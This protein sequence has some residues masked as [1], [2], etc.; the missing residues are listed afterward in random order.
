M[1]EDSQCHPDV[2]NSYACRHTHEVNHP[3]NPK[4]EPRLYIYTKFT[5]SSAISLTNVGGIRCVWSLWSTF[6]SATGSAPTPGR[7]GGASF[8]P[9]LFS[10]AL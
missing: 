4:F 3:L 6:K 5:S 1:K 2:L 8:C 10:G 7:E 9:S